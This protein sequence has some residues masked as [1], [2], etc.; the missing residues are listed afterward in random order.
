MIQLQDTQ[1]A[2]KKNT[3]GIKTHIYAYIHIKASKLHGSL[4]DK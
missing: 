1:I 3:M 2:K 4:K